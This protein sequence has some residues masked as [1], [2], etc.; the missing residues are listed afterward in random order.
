M[1]KRIYLLHGC[2]IDFSNKSV[3]FYSSKHEELCEVRT[4]SAVVK[5]L[6]E[7]LK[8]PG[9]IVDYDV[10]YNATRGIHS[11]DT[12]K[13]NAQVVCS[14]INP[15][16]EDIKRDL[17]NKRNEG[18]KIMLADG[19]EPYYRTCGEIEDICGDYYALY[20]D[21]AATNQTGQIL[22]AFI[23]IYPDKAH[24][25]K[26]AATAVL[27]IRSLELL[28]SIAEAF[29]KSDDFFSRFDEYY[30]TLDSAEHDCFLMSGEVI[31]CGQNVVSIALKNKLGTKE[32]IDRWNIV[33]NLKDYMVDARPRTSEDEYYRGGAGLMIG[34]WTKWGIIS[35][36]I[37]LIRKPRNTTEAKLLK[38]EDVLPFLIALNHVRVDE[39][40][41]KSF[42]IW[43]MKKWPIALVS[44]D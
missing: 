28:N 15:L 24:N 27:R 23:R 4:N 11:H 25:S 7:L 9:K 21:P 17:P 38:H 33:L 8:C 36:Q 32:V 43:L 42:Y 29:T 34:G 39:R 14:A 1:H 12:K 18:Y 20:L 22:Q 3:R 10:L 30:A 19:A 31:D 26:M 44:D 41:D 13:T 40:I 6:E 2:Y 5:I 37:V 16:P 35:S